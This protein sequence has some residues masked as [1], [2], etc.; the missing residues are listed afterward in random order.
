[1]QSTRP[2]WSNQLARSEILADQIMRQLELWESKPTKSAKNFS[3]LEALHHAID[4]NGDQMSQVDS[5]LLLGLRDPGTIEQLRARHTGNYKAVQRLTACQKHEEDVALTQLGMAQVIRDHIKT[6]WCSG[7]EPR[8]YVCD[9]YLRES[10]K[11]MLKELDFT[12]IGRDGLS[13]YINQNTLVYAVNMDD[14]EL[15][16]RVDFSWNRDVVPPAAVIT[17]IMNGALD[18]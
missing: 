5:I 1:M 16:M 7:K 3:N 11:S 15:Q 12:M 6:T 9:E 10:T 18:A 2:S 14:R 4:Q 17:Q 8:L 13:R